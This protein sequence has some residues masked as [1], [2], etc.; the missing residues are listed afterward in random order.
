M[1]KRGQFFILAAIILM[2][3]IFVLVT[4]VNTY[5]EKML[6]EDF[7]ELSDNYKTEASRV[8]NDALLSGQNPTANGGALQKFTEEYVSY[9]KTID[10]RLGIVYAYRNP[11]TNEIVVDNY[12]TGAITVGPENIFSADEKSLNEVSLDLG[13]TNFKRSIPTKLNIYDKGYSQYSSVGD[14]ISLEIDGVF[15]P[16]NLVDDNLGIVTKDSTETGDLV[17]VDIS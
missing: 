12:Y 11:L 13:G 16:I 14:S 5:E 2:L 17:R 15:Y 7:P 10:P 9:A 3:A 8:V 1:N 6:L 4:K